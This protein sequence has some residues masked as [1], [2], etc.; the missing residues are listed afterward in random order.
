LCFLTFLRALRLSQTYFHI[1]YQSPCGLS[2]SN[3]TAVLDY[4]QQTRCDFLFLDIFCLDPF[5][6]VT[7]T[8]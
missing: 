7:T 4:L 5:V 2:L 8:H 3:M 6:S 1:F